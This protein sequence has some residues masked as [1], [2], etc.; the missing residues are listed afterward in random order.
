MAKRHTPKRPYTRVWRRIAWRAVDGATMPRCDSTGRTTPPR[1]NTMP[2][3]ATASHDAPRHTGLATKPA[4]QVYTVTCCTIF[5]AASVSAQE[6]AFKKLALR[7][8]PRLG[9]KVSSRG[10][11]ESA[12][13]DTGEPKKSKLWAMLCAGR[14]IQP[15]WLC[16]FRTAPYQLAFPLPA[17][18]FAFA[19]PALPFFVSRFIKF[20][21]F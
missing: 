10:A 18:A 2:C 17:F 19:L 12:T 14:T 16:H 8:V 15:I 4:Y 11:D 13:A 7:R 1:R 21:F 5:C 20:F 3:R 9:A 6:S